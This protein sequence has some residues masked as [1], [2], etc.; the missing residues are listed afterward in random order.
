MADEADGLTPAAVGRA[1]L[2]TVEADRTPVTEL[3]A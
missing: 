3:W 2:A 1:A